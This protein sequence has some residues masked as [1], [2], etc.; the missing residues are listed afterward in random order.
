MMRGERPSPIALTG[1]VLAVLAIALVCRT[2][3]DGERRASSRGSIAVALA[4]GIAIGCFLVAL[5]GASDTAGLWTL[6]IARST[7]L[8]V[9]LPI[10]FTRG[11]RPPRDAVAPI[12]WG[13][14]LD[15]LANVLYLLAVARGMLSV[16]ATLVSLYP[17]ATVILA[18]IV[19][20]ERLSALQ[21]MGVVLAIGAVALIGW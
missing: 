11:I 14:V 3:D 12:L 21:R 7:S 2:P 18:R 4:A 15:M 6:V 20:G 19:Y 16:V 9:L 10:A 1:I 8:I 17:A 13:G 5:D